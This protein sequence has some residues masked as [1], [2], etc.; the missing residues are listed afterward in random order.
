MF[1]LDGDR[2]LLETV[3]VIRQKLKLKRCSFARHR[4]LFHLG[5]DIAGKDGC[6]HGAFNAFSVL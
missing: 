2:S 6:W 1:E 5:A 4:C 3:L